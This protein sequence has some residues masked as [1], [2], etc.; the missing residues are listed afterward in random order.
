MRHMLILMMLAAPA[1]AVEIQKSGSENFPSNH[2]LSAHLGYQAGVGGTFQNPSGLKLTGEYAYRFHELVWFDARVSN[3]FGFGSTGG[4]CVDVVSSDC[5]RGGWAFGL[6][7]GVKLKFRT[8]VPLVVEVPVLLGVDVLYNRDCGDD[9]AAG[10]LVRT[11]GSAK[12]FLTRN[13][14]LGA[15]VNFAFGPGF[16]GGSDSPLCKRSSYVD[17]YG[18]FDFS[19]VAEFLL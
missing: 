10:P 18:A 2:E 5:Y 17:F 8:P 6:A 16:H 12:Y 13:I 1:G 7:G 9:G 11:G 3:V 4:P 15:A 14:G 19:L